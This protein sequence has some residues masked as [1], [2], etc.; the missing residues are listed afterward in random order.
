M[1]PKK[2]VSQPKKPVSEWTAADWAKL[3]LKHQDRP[4]GT[5]PEEFYQR[6]QLRAQRSAAY[7]LLAIGEALQAI[8]DRMP[9]PP[10]QP[11]LAATKASQPP[12]EA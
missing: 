6:Q 10:T 7:A 1:S 11:P 12:R 5:S 9:E 3:Y 2:A 8:A 4:E